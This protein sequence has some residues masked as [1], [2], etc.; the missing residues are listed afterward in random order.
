MLLCL[1][2]KSHRIDLHQLA[3]G[4][5]NT[6]AAPAVPQR[7]FLW[8]RGGGREAGWG[9]EGWGGGGMGGGGGRCRKKSKMWHVAVVLPTKSSYASDELW[10]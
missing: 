7:N 10:T 4:Y 1:L 2:E 6:R 3:S 9:G 8:G 5:Q